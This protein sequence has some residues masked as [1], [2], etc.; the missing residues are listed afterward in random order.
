MKRLLQPGIPAIVALLSVAMFVLILL[1]RKNSKVDFSTEIKPILNK[2][3][4]SCHGGVKAQGGFSVL[5]REEALAVTESGKPAI[6][7]GDPE[8]SEM[9]KRILS[10]DPEERMPYRHEPLSKDEVGLIK[11]WI[12]QG[13]E[14]G[15]HWAYLPV[16]ETPA[17][18]LSSSWIRSDI[19][20]FIYAKLKE[21][22]LAPSPEADKFT[23]LRRVSLDLTGMYPG[24]TIARKFL[25]SS[26]EDAYEELVDSLLASKRF[27]EKWAGMWLDLSRY[28]DTKGYES[29]GGR[30]IWRYRDWLIKAFNDDMPYDEFITGQIA[31]DLLPAATDEQYI[32]TAFSRNTMTNDEGGTDNEEFRIAA[33]MDRVNTTWEALM[34]TTFSCVQ[35]H[36]HPYDPFRHEEYYRF[37]AFFNNTRDEDI[38]ADYPLLREFKDD[39]LKQHF[40]ELISW[41]RRHG[42][43]QEA[44]KF[45]SFVRTWQPSVNMVSADS[46][47]NALVLNK[48]VA[49]AF[50]NHAR[51]RLKNVDLENAGQMVWNYFSD[52]KNGT[53]KIRMD[54]PEG[55]VL[56]S[57]AIQPMNKWR[58]EFIEF[59]RQKGIHD[60]YLTY[61]NP[62]LP[63]KSDNFYLTFDWV[64]FLPAVPEAPAGEAGNYRKIFRDLVTTNDVTTTPVMME[65]PDW[66]RRKTQVFDRGNRLLVTNTVE[67]AVP[68]SLSFPMPEGTP[69]NRLGLARWLTDKRNPLVSRTMVNRIWEQ[70]FGTGIV[71]TL[72]DM[73]TQGMLPTHQDLLD[74]LSWKF[75]NDFKWSTKA[76]LKAMV[77]S[78][79]YRQDSRISNELAE[80]DPSNKWY[81]RGPRLRLSAEQVRDQALSI[82]GLMSAKMYGPSVMP[83]QPPGIWLS[84]YNRADWKNS[85]GEDQYR[86]ALYTYWKRTAPY[87]SMITFDGMPRVLCAARRIRTNTPLQALVTLNDSA[88]LDMARHFAARMKEEGGPDLA[89]QLKKGYAIAT[90]RPLQENKLKVFEALYQKAYAEF[91]QDTLR[92]KQMLGG[93]DKP[94]D[95]RSAALVVVANAMMNLDELIMK[96]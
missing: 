63:A 69:A 35:C 93:P 65:N 91:R 86:R 26:E 92:T 71:E 75:M 72:E 64:G 58:K 32:A 84:P 96:N 82:S 53:L 87:P 5:F 85:S 24:N 70:L 68:Q 16:K 47:E 41:I 6:I 51:A 27:G 18:R 37:M 22:K 77:M 9:I 56:A 39:T 17:P 13:A 45:D 31:G 7:P 29:D 52:T 94:S 80:K 83:W 59:P 78:A 3:C 23:L 81:A 62:S 67:P 73:G 15:D 48:N 66:M 76:L 42:S 57:V 60:I 10:D 21:E 74:H 95:A 50:S 61:E 46:L 38:P 55:P 40:A 34:S 14:W 54:S 90:Y 88:Y 2:K 8:N 28:A 43:E 30:Q 19:D 20:R 12:R 49:L 25:E 44:G 11:R 79:T 1:V 89:G 36:S 33:V 4:I